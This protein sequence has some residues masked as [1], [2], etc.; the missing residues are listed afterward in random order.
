MYIFQNAI[1][2][3]GRNKGRNIL[4]GIIIL[5]IIITTVVS[6]IINN[7]TSEIIDNYKSEFGAKVSIAP[8]IDKIMESGKRGGRLTADQYLSFA[9]SD[10]IK[11]SKLSAE[12][13]TSS[14]KLK[15]IGQDEDEKARK[16][17]GEGGSISSNGSG[18]EVQIPTMKLK[19][20]SDI[21]NLEEFKD[22]KRKIIDGRIYKAENEC[23][24][25]KEFAKLNNISVGD[26]I[27]V[28]GNG[29][30]I[31]LTVTGLYFDTT[32]EFGGMPIHSSWANRRN[33]ILTTFNTIINA[34]DE[35]VMIN[36]SY[37]LKNPDLLPKFE[38]ELRTK[39]LA[40]TF[41]VSADD[42]GYDKVVGPVEGLKSISM[43]FMIVVLILG[44][45]ILVLLSSIS[46]RERKYEVGVLRAMGMKKGKVAAGFITE[47]LII[48]TICLVI[49]LGIG[50][51]SSQPIA[52]AL[53][54]NQ[55]TAAEN[56]S[57]GA[58]KMMSFG[59]DS[60]TSNDKP[61]SELGAHL[62]LDS[63]WKISLIALLLASAS[64]IVSTSKITKYEP[65]K[66]LMERN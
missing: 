11:E 23:I 41:V 57:A 59:S 13:Q 16:E 8:D 34:K 62:S 21:D 3:V 26:S 1:K 29:K 52:N 31:K 25:S 49:G 2:N 19:G 15:G 48:T 63:L 53:L 64:S 4:M 39:G 58:D 12:I 37:Y 46:V 55:I 10:Y 44:M 9:K 17:E 60:D 45:L 56:A 43:T 65:I 42:A 5:I 35:G 18:K 6:L 28:K 32:D 61:V 51:V 47:S 33:E 7:A 20:E 36:A 38:A 50:S 40:D 22:G 14:E 66:I 24:L 54:K 30:S 27:T